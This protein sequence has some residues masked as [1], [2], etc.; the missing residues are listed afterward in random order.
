VR[1]TAH[2]G[3]GAEHSDGGLRQVLERFDVG[4]VV[5][6]TETGSAGLPAYPAFPWPADRGAVA[7]LAVSRGR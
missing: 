5:R 6:P 7:P 3:S 2:S 1:V 4:V